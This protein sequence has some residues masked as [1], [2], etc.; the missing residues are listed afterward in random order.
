MIELS[1]AF[2]SYGEADVLENISLKIEKGE[3]IAIMGKSGSGK[4]TLVKAIAGLLKAKS[5]E[6]LVKTE[7]IAYVFQEPRLLPWLSALENV[8]FVLAENEADTEKASELLEELELEGAS[9]KLPSELSGGMQQ[10]VSIARALAFGADVLILD[11]PFSAL[12]EKLKE[13][14]ISLIKKRAADIALIFVTHDICDARALCDKIY[15]IE[16]K[17]LN[18]GA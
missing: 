5:G 12:D 14:T 11:E 15:Y 16:D 10:R 18:Q 7:K 2:F 13:K 9:E 17:H 1:N 8:M 4:T 3:H 6:V